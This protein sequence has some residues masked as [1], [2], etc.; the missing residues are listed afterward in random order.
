MSPDATRPS[1]RTLEPDGDPPEPP[2]LPDLAL[3]LQSFPELLEWLIGTH[4]RE[5]AVRT[6]HPASSLEPGERPS[7]ALMA[8]VLLSVGDLPGS[9]RRSPIES[10]YAD[11]L[12]QLRTRSARR[13]P[14]ECAE[15]VVLALHLNA[16]WRALLEEKAKEWDAG[17]A[18]RSY[19][20]NAVERAIRAT[21]APPREQADGLGDDWAAASLPGSMPPAQRV[22]PASGPDTAASLAQRS[23][24]RSLILTIVA[25]VAVIVFAVAVGV[26]IKWVGEDNGKSFPPETAAASEKPQPQT[27]PGSGGGSVP[28]AEMRVYLREVE[29][30]MSQASHG[31]LRI[32]KA[33]TWFRTGRASKASAVQMIQTVIDN[34]N[35]AIGALATL[36]VPADVKAIA[37]HAAFRRALQYSV[38]ADESYMDYVAGWASLAAAQPDNKQAGR[39]KRTFVGRYNRLAAQCGMAHDWSMKD[40]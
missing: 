5:W 30:L 18:F 35:A 23:R 2:A 3:D 22:P 20:K 37:C 29:N 17:K 24:S 10:T 19:R 33:V 7:C 25:V 27:S 12:Q 28:V 15:R 39:W 6:Y 4:Y 1:A 21:I 9:E 32:T 14:E 40:F 38:R 13:L 31:R 26:A 11:A 16:E 8:K 34:R 36:T